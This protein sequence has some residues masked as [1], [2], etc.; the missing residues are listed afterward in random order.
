MSQ[1][2]VFQFLKEQEP[3]RWLSAK[4]ISK[5]VGLTYGSISISLKKLKKYKDIDTKYQRDGKGHM[6][7]YYK[8]KV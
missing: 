3:F 4:E 2:K 7:F 1:E 5:E 6:V 8:Y